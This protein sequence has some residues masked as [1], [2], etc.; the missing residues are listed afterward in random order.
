MHLLTYVGVF[1]LSYQLGRDIKL[2]NRA[3]QIVSLIGT[4]YCSYGLIVYL[5][6][7]DTILIFRKWAY[8]ASL[9]S[10]FV[11]RNNFATFA[12]L[13]LLCSLAYL[14]T[15]LKPVLQQN[16][17]GREMLVLVLE[18]LLVRARWYLAATILT[19]M[20]LLL[21]TS[22]GGVASSLCAAAFLVFLVTGRRRRKN[23]NIIFLIMAGTALSALSIAFV[24]AGQG[25]AQRIVH[26]GFEASADSRLSIYSIT[27]DGIWSAP[28]TGVGFGTYQDAI[29]AY[30]RS[31]MSPLLVWDK[32]HNTYLENTFELGIPGAMLLFASIFILG[33]VSLRGVQNRRRN[34]H[35]PAIG[36]AATALIGLHSLVDFS[37]Q[38][39]AVA[40]L[41]A[42][43]IGNATA[44]CS[45]SA[46][47]AKEKSFSS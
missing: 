3:L 34:V 21:T 42:Y 6:G 16:R 39:P 25:L 35:I 36:A 37:M 28:W 31:D 40:M 4:I 41:F 44:Q 19:S 26:P 8:Q 7:N 33:A 12:G 11:N 29:T 32:A 30:M 18:Q 20:A 5:L 14:L 43:I 46:R 24:V 23:S 10:T 9:T 47:T 1:Y 45:P 17:R 13:S 38:I 22:R 2:A 27:A 15:S